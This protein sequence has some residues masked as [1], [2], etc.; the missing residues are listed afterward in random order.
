[1]RFITTTITII[2]LLLLSCL[3]STCP[4]SGLDACDKIEIERQNRLKELD[5]SYEDYINS[6]D[7]K[8]QP[9]ETIGPLDP[10][11][12]P[13]ADAALAYFMA[14]PEQVNDTTGTLYA[15]VGRDLERNTWFFV[16]LYEH[17]T[18]QKKYSKLEDEIE[19]ETAEKREKQYC[20][21]VNRR[22]RYN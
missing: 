8:G 4:E 19:N 18:L 22:N 12:Y 14:Q 21:P 13:N 1:M 10:I 16:K 11:L 9:I 5:K 20:A 17:G 3:N 7:I 6:F 2:G 15:I